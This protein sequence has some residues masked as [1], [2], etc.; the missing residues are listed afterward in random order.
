MIPLSVNTLFERYANDLALQWLSNQNDTHRPLCFEAD[1]CV[2][3]IGYLNFIRPQQIQII[4]LYELAYLEELPIH[5]GEDTLNRLFS[6]DKLV[7]V[8][9]V[10]AIKVSPQLIEYANRYNV[11]LLASNLTGEKVINYLHT[12]FIR[13]LAQQVTLHGVFMDV[14]GVGILITG[15][16]GIGKS[17]LALELVS[18][19]HRLVADDAPEFT[20]VTPQRIRGSCAFAGMEP[21]LEVRGLGILNV[22]AMFGDSSVKKEKYLRLIVRLESLTLERLKNAE[23]LQGE[24]GV[25]RI[26]DVDI[27]EICLP[28]APGRNLAVLLECAVRNH[29]LKE[30]GYDAV[31]DFCQRQRRA[32]Q[33]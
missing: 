28:V 8:V 27:P 30:Q 3:S 10:D 31:K 11:P 19:G 33:E 14:L 7:S 9:T 15:D 32:M 20:R 12:L 21:F 24:Y 5:V 17:E 16:S 25:R 4:G 2:A 23:R 26:L 29:S 13:L 22:Q 1:Q 18:R 6:N